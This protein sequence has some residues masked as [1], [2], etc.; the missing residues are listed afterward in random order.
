MARISIDLVA[1]ELGVT[2]EAVRYA[3]NR[4]GIPVSADGSFNYPEVG[5]LNKRWHSL[6]AS[7][8]A[9]LAERLRHDLGAP[10]R[11]ATGN[12]NECNPLA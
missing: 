3:C 6:L 7:R 8:P 10:V 5:A 9:N 2:H 12:R 4:L 1:K 11:R